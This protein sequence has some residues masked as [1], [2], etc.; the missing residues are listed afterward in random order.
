LPMELRV[1]LDRRQEGRKLRRAALLVARQRLLE[2]P[3]P[4]RACPMFALEAVEQR[5]SVRMADAQEIKQI[6]ILLRMMEALGKRID[7]VDH[8]AEHVEIRT[9]AAIADGVH[10]MKHAVQDRRQRTM[11]VV[12]D[13]VALHSHLLSGARRTRR[14]GS[15]PIDDIAPA[16]KPIDVGQCPRGAS[17]V[18][19]LVPDQEAPPAPWPE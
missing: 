10:Q 5:Y 19:T 2:R 15:P 16:P 12:N 6:L 1:I 14:H 13:A 8:R 11:L 4:F 17:A 7:V 9:H 18:P 3:D